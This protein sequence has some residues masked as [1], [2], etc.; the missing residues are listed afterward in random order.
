MHTK[1]HGALDCSRELEIPHESPPLSFEHLSSFASLAENHCSLATDRH[2]R[3][4]SRQALARTA[5]GLLAAG[6]TPRHRG[7]TRSSA[8]RGRVAQQLALPGRAAP[9]TS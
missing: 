1:G 7:L 4:S 3:R 6:D 2:V 8:S 5:W 9:T